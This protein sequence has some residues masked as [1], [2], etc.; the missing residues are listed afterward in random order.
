MLLAEIED[1]FEIADRAKIHPGIDF[2]FTP[3][4]TAQALPKAWKQWLVTTSV[5]WPLT[6]IVPL[7]YRPL[8]QAIPLLGKWGISHGIIAST[9]VAL[10]V[11][12]IMPRSVRAVSTWLHK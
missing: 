3:P 7:M 6:L 9:V 1:S 5:I 11:F 8:F 10:V 12:L 2:W 4:S